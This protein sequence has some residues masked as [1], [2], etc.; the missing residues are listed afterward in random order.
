[1]NRDAG[2]AF[3]HMV[4]GYHANKKASLTNVFL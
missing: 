1:M 2:D 3:F 4:M